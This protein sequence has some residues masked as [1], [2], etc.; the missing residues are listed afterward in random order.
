MNIEKLLIRKITIANQTYNLFNDS[1]KLL[2]A[3]SGG[4]DSMALL[5]ILSKIHPPDLIY[6]VH[7][8]PYRD[9]SLLNYIRSKAE[10]FLLRQDPLFVR[11][12]PLYKNTGQTCYECARGRRMEIF[13]TADKENIKKIVFAHT[14]NDVA[15]TFLMN[16]LYNGSTDTIKPLQDFF[17]GK[18]FVIRPFYLVENKEALRYSGIYKIEP[19]DYECEAKK[20]NKRE[21]VR[22]FL[23]SLN[24]SYVIQ[25]VFLSAITG[26]NIKKPDKKYVNL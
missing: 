24:D 2:V 22:N 15:E 6:A 14:K 19:R 4:K 8:P 17:N 16:I 11:E 13:K 12:N 20:E 5:K 3:I 18:F 26:N 21:V 1:E 7:I 10:E 9:P 23:A 25:R